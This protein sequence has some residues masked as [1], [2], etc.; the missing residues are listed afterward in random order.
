VVQALLSVK[1]LLSKAKDR[2]VQL[3][4]REA[5]LTK[6]TKQVYTA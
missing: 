3:E 2:Q 5:E 1:E 6:E 4:K